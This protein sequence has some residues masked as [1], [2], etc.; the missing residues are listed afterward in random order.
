MTTEQLYTQFVDGYFEKGMDAIPEDWPKD[1]RKRCRFFLNLMESSQQANATLTVES[2]LDA[3]LVNQ[4]PA[5]PEVD[6]AD[7]RLPVMGERYLIEREIAAGGMGRIL[8]AYDRD[9]RRRVA[10]KI[11]KSCEQTQEETANFIAEAQATAQ[12]EHPNIGP[13]YDLGKDATGCHFFSMKWIRGRNLDQILGAGDKE[14][15][16]TR[17]VQIVQQAAMGVHF[18]NSRGVIHRDLKPQNIMVGDYGEVLAVDWGLAKVLRGATEEPTP[19]VKAGELAVSTAQTGGERFTI[20]GAIQ[21]SLAY[22]APEQALGKLSEIDARTDVFGLGAILYEVLTG[23]PP[24]PGSSLEEVLRRAQLAEVPSLAERAP[25]RR[26]PQALENTCLK[27]MARRKEDRFQNAREFHDELQIYIEGIHDAERRAEEVRRLR[28]AAEGVRREFL[29]AEAAAQRL[30]EETQTLRFSVDP[31]D[32]AEKKERLWKLMDEAAAAREAATKSFNHAAAAYQAVLSIEPQD[33]TAR[34]RLGQL[35]LERLVEAEERGDRTAADLYEGLVRQFPR[36]PAAIQLREPGRLRLESN[37]P[38]ARVRICAYERRGLQ[39]VEGPWEDL[40]V[41]PLEKELRRGSYLALLHH[42]GHDETRYPLT[43]ARGSTRNATVR[44][45]AHGTLPPGFLHVPSGESI[46]GSSLEDLRL[47]P[48]RRVTPDTFA[49]GKF[50]VT[51]GEYC[52]FLDNAFPENTDG[53]DAVLPVFGKEQY[54]MLDDGGRWHAIERLGPDLPVLAIP[55]GAALAYCAWLSGSLDV[56]VRLPTEEEWERCARGAD[57]RVYPWG[58]G[59]D[60]SFCK[61]AHSRS[62]PPFPEAVG[63]YP[64]DV[65]PFEVRDLAGGVREFCYGRIAEGLGPLRG[66]SWFQ[67]PQIVFRAEFRSI[68]QDRARHTDVGFRVGFGLRRR[69]R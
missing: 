53:L 21:G 10:L 60:E 11:I 2:C 46:V 66:G 7:G 34:S 35:Y 28:L 9:L 62:G 20:D 37:P 5:L 43:L 15:T 17:L 36:T 14:F 67:G 29:E 40:G 24:Y 61:G 68:Q 3:S 64:L 56:H 22:M 54:V 12:L 18:A 63:A 19:P 6:G 39:L 32:P 38:G 8:L 44:L 49:I 26:F 42:A 41:T 31:Y 33:A 48:R 69:S 45:L 30:E 13:V 51:F 58:N 25:K 1:L 57:G 4:D 65:S 16:L 59:F 52:K 50:P 27:A 23:V 47:P 55:R